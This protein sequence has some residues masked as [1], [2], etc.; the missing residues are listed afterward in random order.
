MGEER[1]LSADYLEP[2]SDFHSALEDRPSQQHRCL[3][4]DLRRDAINILVRRDCPTP[5]AA[6]W[7]VGHRDR[8]LKDFDLRPIRL[9]YSF[10]LVVEPV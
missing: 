2:Q 7:R 3:Y 10:G 8:I 1:G 6:A 9:G 5:N 4:S